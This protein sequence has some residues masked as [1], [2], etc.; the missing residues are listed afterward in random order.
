[1]RNLTSQSVKF[2]LRLLAAVDHSLQLKQTATETSLNDK[3]NTAI[4]DVTTPLLAL[5]AQMAS[6]T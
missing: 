3:L 4:G 5:G 2:F 1:M 6:I